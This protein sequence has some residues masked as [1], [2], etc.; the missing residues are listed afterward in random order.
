MSFVDVVRKK[1]RIA[2]NIEA[3][4]YDGIVVVGGS[5]FLTDKC[6]M[7]LEGVTAV[8]SLMAPCP[9]V[10]DSRDPDLDVT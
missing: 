9:F 10:L 6:G 2:P 1:W 4:E 3:W 7:S 8:P 5:I